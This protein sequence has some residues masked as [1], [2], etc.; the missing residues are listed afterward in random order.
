MLRSA[1]ALPVID[2]TAARGGGLIAVVLALFSA[3]RRLARV[4]PIGLLALIDLVVVASAEVCRGNLGLVSDS[5]NDSS[6]L[7]SALNDL[8]GLFLE[9]TCKRLFVLGSYAE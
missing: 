6:P 3:E 1:L 2:D 5:S 4:F 8:Y 7:F 9:I